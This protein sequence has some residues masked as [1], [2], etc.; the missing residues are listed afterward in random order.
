M[1]VSCDCAV[2]ELRYINMSCCVITPVLRKLHWISVEHRTVLKQPHLISS[3]FT[4]LSPMYYSPYRSSY[5]SSYSTRQSLSGDNFLVI[6]MFY[7]SIQKSVRQFGYSFAFDALNVWNAVP[8][9]I[10]VSL[11]VA[12]F[13]KQLKTYLFT[14]TYQP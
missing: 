12:S 13:R 5:S 9:E 1:I 10:P 7:H 14:K 4:L 2:V 8:G 6:Q 11:S 3:F